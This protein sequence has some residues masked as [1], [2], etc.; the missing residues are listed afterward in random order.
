MSEPNPASSAGML[1]CEDNPASR[2]M[3]EGD[4]AVISASAVG[5]RTNATPAIAAIRLG[6]IHRLVCEPTT[7]A[8]RLYIGTI[9]RVGRVYYEFVE[10]CSQVVG[11][12]HRTDRRS[13]SGTF[14]F[15]R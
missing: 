7:P 10:T 4:T 14:A 8:L 1:N 6:A 13:D 2:V 12:D 5:I 15:M 11:L 3:E 9:R